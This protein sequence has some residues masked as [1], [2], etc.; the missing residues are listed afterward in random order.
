MTGPGAW[1][2]PDLA[3]RDDWQYV[4]SKVSVAEILDAMVHARARRDCIIDMIRDDFP[5]PTF[6]ATCVI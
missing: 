5:L 4:L 3:A 6:G 1:Y 2:G